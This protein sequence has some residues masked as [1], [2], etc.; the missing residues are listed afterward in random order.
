MLVLTRKSEETIILD[1]RVVLKILRIK[2]ATV[3]VGIEA[4][5]D[6]RIMRGELC[7]THSEDAG[8]NVI[9]DAA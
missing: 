7:G 9:S 4:P 3:R 2:G 1:G 8:R 6:V 5:A